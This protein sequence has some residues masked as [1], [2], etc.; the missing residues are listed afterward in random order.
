MF[1]HTGVWLSH[2]VWSRSR[3][4]DHFIFYLLL[5][6][7]FPTTEIKPRTTDLSGH[8]DQFQALSHRGDIAE[9]ISEIMEAARVLRHIGR[10][11]IFCFISPIWFRHAGAIDT[12]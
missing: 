6:V 7:W 4:P 10:F 5:I 1:Y 9:S 11:D 12:G 8:I 2:V 3:K